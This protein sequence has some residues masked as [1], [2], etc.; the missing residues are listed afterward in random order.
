MEWQLAMF[1]KTLKKKMRLRHLK[2]HLRPLSPGMKCFFVTCGDNNGAM[3][4]FLRELGGE[5]FWADLERKSI[6]EMEDLL[7]QTVEH[8]R[9]DRLP[10]PD[11]SFDVV[12]AVD[13][14]EHIPDPRPFTAELYRITRENGQVIVTVPNGNEKKTATRIKNAVGMTKEKYGHVREGLDLPE[15]RQLL[16]GARF[17]PDKAT[18]FSRFFTEMLEL[19]INFLYVNVL[20]KK[21]HEPVGEG[22]IAPATKKQLESV[23][24]ALRAYSLVYP[25]FWVISRLDLLVLYRRGYVVMVSGSKVRSGAEELAQCRVER[26]TAEAAMVN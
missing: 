26:W 14:H 4:Y 23:K 16:E 13:V 11:N 15:L 22:T 18:T 10:F 17:R 2:L 5:W 9:P 8:V 21:S 24:K 1:R 6:A 3:N 7:G 25:L 12:I 20:A 19:S